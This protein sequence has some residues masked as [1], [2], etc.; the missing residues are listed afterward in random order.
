MRAKS[1]NSPA[2]MKSKHEIRSNQYCISKHSIFIC[3][4]ISIHDGDYLFLFCKW[5]CEWN[6]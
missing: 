2:R 5:F 3:F 1:D 6:V 4:G